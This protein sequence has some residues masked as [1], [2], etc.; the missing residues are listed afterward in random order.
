M[1]LNA[2]KMDAETLADLALLIERA[3]EEDLRGGRDCT[4][5]AL[6]PEAVTG[7]ARFVAR[8][9]GVV[10]GIGVVEQVLKQWSSPLQLEVRAGDG[11]GVH[12]G[13]VLAELRGDAREILLVERTCLN[14]LGR[15]SGIATLTRQYVELLAGCPGRLFDTRKTT[16]GWR[17]LEKYAVRCGGGQNHRMGLYDAVLIKDNHLAMLR[18]TTGDPLAGVRVAVERARAW[19]DA[20]AEEL[21]QGRGTILQIEVDRLD[22][23]AEALPLGPD[24]VLLDNM[25]PDEL[26]A[27][28]ELRNRVAPDVELEASGG[29]NLQ[30]IAAIGK[31]GVERISVG[32]VTHSATN[33]DIG[34]DWYLTVPASET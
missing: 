7:G 34:L 21:P 17:R 32:A 15:L 11:E 19:I 2:V 25:G 14:F 23:L 8:G 31:T 1:K 12:A 24:I 28:V 13:D 27:A 29:V 9:T 20:H 26:A 10:C 22:Q 5:S 16:P 33:F 3:R 4:S 18:Q 6:F 30:T